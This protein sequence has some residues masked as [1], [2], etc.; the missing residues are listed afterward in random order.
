MAKSPKKTVKTLSDKLTKINDSF[1][2][3]LYDNGFM[4][5]AGGR[6][7]ND[8]WITAKIMVSTIEDLVTVIRE[9]ADM[10]RS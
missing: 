1:T 5:E 7:D 3:N 4:V 10:E 8:E 6:D 2:V 9:A